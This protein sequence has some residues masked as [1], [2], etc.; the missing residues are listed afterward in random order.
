MSFRRFGIGLAVN[1]CTVTQFFARLEVGNVF[2][3]QIHFVT[4]F[5]VTTGARS[6]IMQ[7]KAAESPDFNAFALCQRRG[8]VLQHFFDCILNDFRRYMSML[9]R[10][11][12]NQF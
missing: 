2:T 1:V 4:R 12:F 7:R 10:Q 6:A 8:H 5:R 11:P 3:F 9:S